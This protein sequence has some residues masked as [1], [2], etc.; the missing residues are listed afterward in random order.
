MSVD[1]LRG[2]LGWCAIINYGV[3]ILWFL[4]FRLA[5]DWIYR[6]HSQ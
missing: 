3:L 4:V 6:L 1:V 2:L 5:H